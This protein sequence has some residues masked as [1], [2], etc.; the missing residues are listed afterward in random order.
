MRSVPPQHSPVAAP[1]VAAPLLLLVLSA[2]PPPS[3]TREPRSP[4]S[5]AGPAVAG[6]QTPTP[7]SAQGPAVA[8]LPQHRSATIPGGLTCLLRLRRLG[9]PHRPLQN[10]YLVNTPVEVLGPVAGVSYKPTWRARLI[11]DCRFALALHRAGPF[12]RALGV[13]TAYFSNT[14]RKHR[15]S[16]RR[17]S[18]HGLGLAMDLHRL[19]DPEG[20]LLRVKADY[21]KG[22]DNACDNSDRPLLNR[23]ACL[24]KRHG[25]FDYVLTPDTDRA[26]YDHFHFSILDLERR[27]RSHRRRAHPV[28][29][30]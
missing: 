3:T 18:R 15:G 27:R 9:I 1:L 29:R 10:V 20:K 6:H 24:L 16:L 25:V 2:C 11:V 26:H 23:L 7:I 14:Y 17:V 28:V 19:R 4:M 30:H 8:S 13:R 5:A 12:F 21:E 22:L